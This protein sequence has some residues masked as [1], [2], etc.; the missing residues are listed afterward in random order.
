MH[1][2][3]LCRYVGQGLGPHDAEKR[4]SLACVAAYHGLTECLQVF[5]GFQLRKTGS[6]CLHA[7]DAGHLPC[8][9][10]AHQLGDW[11]N[12]Y[13]AIQAAVQGGCQ[14]KYPPP[15][16]PTRQS[17]A[18]GLQ[19]PLGHTQ[20]PNCRMVYVPYLQVFESIVAGLSTRCPEQHY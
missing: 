15:I 7:A 10:L 17:A 13:S 5:E 6:I 2:I 14:Y 12:T 19:G 8:L 3:S 1:V 11:L 9:R 18:L 4:S 20:Q 16:C